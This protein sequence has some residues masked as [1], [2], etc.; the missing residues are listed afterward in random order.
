MACIVI[1][2]VLLI[3]IVACCKVF[4]GRLCSVVFFSSEMVLTGRKADLEDH[5][6]KRDEAGRGLLI[7]NQCCP[8][9]DKP[10]EIHE[11]NNNCFHPIPNLCGLP[12]T[13]MRYA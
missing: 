2:C 11:E 5:M 4:R 10:C 13:L 3:Q 7:E 9:Y 6:G 12:P 1:W 8:P